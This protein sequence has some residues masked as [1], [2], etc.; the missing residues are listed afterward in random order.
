MKEIAEIYSITKQTAK[1]EKYHKAIIHICDKYPKSEK[2]LSFK[3]E[4]LNYLNKSYKSLETTG[5]LLNVNPFNINA[6]INLA[7]HLKEE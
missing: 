3:I 4:S 2:M 6:L 7:K 1:S 5:N